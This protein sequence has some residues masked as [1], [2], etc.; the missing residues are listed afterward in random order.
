LLIKNQ[1]VF[2]VYLV[3]LLGRGENIMGMPDVQKCVLCQEAFE[4]IKD[5]NQHIIDNHQDQ[6]LIYIGNGYKC[7]RQNCNETYFSCHDRDSCQH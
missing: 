5:Y 7:T 3:L 4:K 1:K 6:G 2:N